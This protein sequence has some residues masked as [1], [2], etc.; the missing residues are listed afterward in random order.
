MR[1]KL[2]ENFSVDNAKTNARSLNGEYTTAGE[3]ID[4][5]I[6]PCAWGYPY[7]GL[8]FEYTSIDGRTN[9][10]IHDKKI[11]CET[12]TKKDVQKLL[13][14]HLTKAKCSTC[15]GSYLKSDKV[16]KKYQNTLCTLC[17]HK[18]VKLKSD[19]EQKQEANK[20]LAQDKQQVKSGH[21]FR[22]TAWIHPK[23]GDDYTLDFYY[24]VLPSDS[25]IKNTIKS[26]G[27][28]VLDD[29][30]TYDI[31]KNQPMN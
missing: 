6:S 15:D 7:Y 22:I 24:K 8:Q 14:D 29:Y 18:E 27:S 30:F 5:K 1:I 16:E 25:E 23:S 13:D 19:L 31:V 12:A 4:V 9:G 28:I 17:N 11:G 10:F 21:K 3:S 2:F 20:L 26:K